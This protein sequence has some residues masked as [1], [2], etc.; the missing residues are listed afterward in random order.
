MAGTKFVVRRVGS[1]TS[2][3]LPSGTEASTHRYV[4]SSPFA[5]VPFPSRV[6]ISS[7]RTDL[8][9]PASATGITFSK[10]MVTMSVE[11]CPCVSLTDSSITYSP[12]LSAS[13]VGDM[14]TLEGK[15]TDANGDDVTYR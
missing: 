8:L 5:S 1:A 11:L 9:T 13:K 15:G 3:L 7:T 2:D 10:L 6:T 4:T 14:V 12:H